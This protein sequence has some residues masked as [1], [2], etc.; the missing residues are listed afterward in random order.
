MEHGAFWYYAGGA[1]SEWTLRENRRAW[2]RYTLH[3]EVLTDVSSASLGVE[4]LGAHR[5]SPLVVAP[6]AFQQLLGYEAEVSMA[7]G[8]RAA[9]VGMTLSTRSSRR[10]GD[11]ASAFH[12]GVRVRTLVESLPK[13]HRDQIASFGS[14]L[15]TPPLL[16]QVYAANDRRITERILEE[17]VNAGFEALIYTIDMPT[18]GIR[19]RDSRNR[20]S[21]VGD[22]LP[23]LVGDELY[24]EFD[25]LSWYHAS[26][27][28]A[29]MSGDDIEHMGVRTG[30]PVI[31][32]GV[33]TSAAYRHCTVKG[34]AEVWISNHGGRQLDGASS[35]A[36]A[37][38]SLR[39]ED[40]ASPRPFC[41]DGGIRR[42]REVGTALAMGA[43]SVAIGKQA[44]FALATGGASGVACYFI[45]LQVEL[46][47][48][49]QLLGVSS[50]DHLRP[51][52]VG[53]VA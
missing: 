46:L 50:V 26:I 51:A 34:A 41:V 27:G 30:L 10:P 38:F 43:Q 13:W 6:M 9:G 7:I 32:K 42:A 28:R 49:L 20:F 22:L 19:I 45:E 12:D 33:L 3:P 17:A 37:L 2:R 25:P 14:R 40:G 29:D 18:L 21:L 48:L 16:Y 5:P 44:A 53:K 36:D 8:A 11:V 24:G 15:G 23:E 35:S 52:M 31:A 39:S 47:N 1:G 4:L